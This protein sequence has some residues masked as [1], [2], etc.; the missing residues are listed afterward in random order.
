MGMIA[1]GRNQVVSSRE[2]A[3][4]LLDHLN[5]EALLFV[6]AS[7]SARSITAQLS[8]DLKLPYVTATTFLTNKM[9]P[10][11][12][13]EE[14]AQVKHTL[15]MKKPVVM[16]ATLS[17]LVLPTLMAWLAENKKLYQLQPV[18]AS[19]AQASK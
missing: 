13:E 18:S 1:S 15:E 19:F 10:R 8:Q 7:L 9:T 5:R 17:P 11:I 4:P 16:V 2:D 14:L 3:L 12:L 6:D